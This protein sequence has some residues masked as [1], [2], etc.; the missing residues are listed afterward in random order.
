MITSFTSKSGKKIVLRP[1]RLGDVTILRNYIN[2]LVAEDA[3]ILFNQ[4]QSQA[5]EKKHLTD[6]LEAINAN[7]RV[8]LLAFHD[9]K[10]IANSQIVKG[11]YRMSHIGIFGISV[12]SG[13][14]GEG[15]G[16]ALSETIIDLAKEKLKIKL[17]DLTVYKNNKA[18]INLYKKLGFKK[19]G[20]LPKAVQ[21]KQ[22]L[23]DLVYMYRWIGKS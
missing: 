10:L 20:L 12:A 22:R 4:R 5:E 1:P 23:V 16:E 8:Q 11:K 17:V 2:N 15:V 7:Q 19:H 3:L 14:R 13:Y 9:E 21:Y 18:A 6:M